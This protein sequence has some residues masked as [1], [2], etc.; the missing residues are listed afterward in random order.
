MFV[1]QHVPF[2]AVERSQNL[3]TDVDVSVLQMLTSVIGAVKA[4]S[5]MPARANIS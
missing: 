5:S 3:N 4:F 1:W 2:K